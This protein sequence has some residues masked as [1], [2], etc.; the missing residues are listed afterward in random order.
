MDAR[1]G[2]GGVAL[3]ITRAER[4]RSESDVSVNAYT[5]VMGLA[6]DRAGLASSGPLDGVQVGRLEVL[7]FCLET[8]TTPLC[9]P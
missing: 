9:S 8:V 1:G 4:W 5:D 6:L 3:P 7:E 2:M